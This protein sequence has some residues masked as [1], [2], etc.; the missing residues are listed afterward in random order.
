[1]KH[2]RELWPYLK[3]SKKILIFA[4]ISSFLATSSKL[5]IPLIAGKAVN[6]MFIEG[7][8][9]STSSLSIYLVLMSTL[10]VVGIIFRFIFDYL[11]SLLGQNVTKSLRDEVYSSY[12]RSPISSIDSKEQGDLLQRLI[13]DV[14]NVQNGLV[15][16]GA[17]FFDG[18]VAILFTL[19]F[20][21]SL[22][23]ALALIVIVL[24]PISM[25]TSRFL[26]RWNSKYFKAQ[27]RSSGKMNSFVQE[28]LT[29]SVS[30]ATLGLEKK[31]EEEFKEL[32]S[33]FKN[34]VYKASFGASLINPATRLV[35]SLI[36]ASIIT[37]G[38]AFIIGGV[39]IGVIFAVGDLSAFLVYASSYMQPFT[40]ISD[41]MSEISYAFA[42]FSR[43]K[44]A[45][46]TPLDKDN[47]KQI[48]EGAFAKI[49]AK[50]V[51][52]SYDNKRDIIK[53][54]NVDA[55]KGTKVALV[56]PTGCGK[57]TL[58]NLLL[59]FYDPQRGSFYANDVSTIDLKK[60]EYRTHLGMV[61]QDTW[62]FNGTVFDNIAYAKPNAT[63]EEVKKAAIAAECDSFIE[64]LPNGYDTLISDSGGL[65]TGQK[66]LLCVA[67]VMLLEPEVIILDE[68]TSNIDIRTESLLSSSFDRLMKGKTSFVV[69]HRLS[70]IVGSDL[71]LVMKDGAIIERGTHKELLE[72]HG[73]YYELYSSQ[74]SA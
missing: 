13:N 33:S 69:A 25:L 29:N 3:K 36:N 11:T 37:C 71:I 6:M 14:E 47:G 2:I 50:D 17:S 53:D 46:D 16:G 39:N 38:A 9:L 28:G 31:R 48:I 30:V 41:V 24:T 52:F 44:E 26:S 58:I 5:A 73:F 21:F 74:F 67:R 42:S 27:A 43:I 15:S 10:L 55:K 22:N 35:N 62:I 59:R 45:I 51:T 32:N 68:A 57:T 7:S 63:L 23:W 34:D 65:S 70:T 19:G 56:G 64:R 40:E 66:Q 49:S 18:V 61:L 20:M 72:K 60:K 4:L 8:S 12:L 1:M 54:F